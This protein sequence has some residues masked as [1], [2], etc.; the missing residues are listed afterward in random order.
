MLR[1][2]D[3]WAGWGDVRRRA[4]EQHR[5]G[6]LPRCS[7]RTKST[8]SFVL[9]DKGATRRKV[10]R[11]QQLTVVANAVRALSHRNKKKR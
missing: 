11:S 10:E 5:F 4:C 7:L 1:S 6:G 3:D 2:S 9:T 8:T